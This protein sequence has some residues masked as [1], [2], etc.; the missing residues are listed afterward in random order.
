LRAG[1]EL[2]RAFDDDERALAQLQSTKLPMPVLAMA[3]ELD[4]ASLIPDMAHDLAV[5]VKTAVV[6]GGGHWTPEEKPAFLLDQ[7][8]S[9]LPS[10]PAR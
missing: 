1:F 10:A 8:L 3:G 2:Y 7:L 9:F 5:D 6:P 4:N